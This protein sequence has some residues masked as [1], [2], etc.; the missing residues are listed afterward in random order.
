MGCRQSESTWE[1]IENLDNCADTIDDYEKLNGLRILSV[2]KGENGQIK[3][4]VQFK[5]G[6][7]EK[8]ESN[9]AERLWPNLV[10]DFLEQRIA[11]T[12]EM[13]SY[14]CM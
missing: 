13:H 11:W 8:V 12:A 4:L 3:Y 2:E 6:F 7:V 5:N 10:A 14:I 1:P 9:R